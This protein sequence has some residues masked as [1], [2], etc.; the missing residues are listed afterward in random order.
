MAFDDAIYKGKTSKVIEVMIR[1]S[2]TGQGK[3]GIAF[4]SVAA[5]YMREGASASSAITVVTATLGTWTSGGWVEVDA[6]NQPG[7][8]Q[9]GVPNAALATGANSVTLSFKISG[10]ID[11]AVKFILID[12]DLR[13]P[14]RAGLTAL[15]NVA[16]GGA[17]QLPTADSSGR[18]T[19]ITNSD[20][21]GY[22]LA[23]SE[24]LIH[25]QNTAQAGSGTTITLDASASS[26]DNFYVGYEI[27]LYSG[28]GSPQSR[29][30]T[31]YNGTTKVATVD[32]PWLGVNPA[33]GTV[34]VIRHL[35]LSA[36][37]ASAKSAIQSADVQTGLTNQGY[38]TTRAAFLDTLNGLVA[39]I[40]AS[41]GRTLTGFGTLVADIWANASRTLSDKAGFS[42]ATPPP[43]AADIRAEIDANSTKLDV[44]VGSR[45]A[46]FAYA[47]PPTVAA[48]RS[49]MDSNSTKLANLDAPVSGRAAP[50]DAMTLTGPTITSIQS[51]LATSASITTLA[52]AVGVVD[53]FVD[54]E[55]N[56]I[57][58]VTDKL[59][60]LLEAD[61][62]T[63]R[64]TVAGLA[65]APAGGGGGGGTADW[66]APEREQIRYRLGMDGTKVAPQEPDLD[67]GFGVL[68]VH[69]LG[70]D[71]DTIT[72]STL[73][74]DALDAID[75][76]LTETHGSGSWTPNLTGARTVQLT[77]RDG[78][79][80]NLLPNVPVKVRIGG[81]L[82]DRKFTDS[83][84]RTDFSLDDGDYLVS[85][86]PAL[87][88]SSLVDQALTVNSEEA[89]TVLLDPI[90]PDAPD[91]PDTRA[92]SVFVFDGL[93]RPLEGKA[94]T[95]KLAPGLSPLTLDTALVSR[96]VQEATTDSDGYAVLYLL[97]QDVFSGAYL[98]TVE[99]T[100]EATIAV[101]PGEG[102]ISL[103][104]LL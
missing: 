18:V 8:Y 31:A 81:Q 2:T 89:A 16:Q 60:T 54:T 49:E 50:G 48:I 15:P 62:P 3:T 98:V 38:T 23:A 24:S 86:G 55:V 25:R 12:V 37:D 75:A 9:F 59:N 45:M 82:V 76:T 11:K 27:S 80:N 61:G 28:T 36:L 1:D 4:G 88:Y 32:S 96:T 6:T 40:W 103:A 79:T 72:A 99:D 22:G 94:V 33:S 92:V 19:V 51:G 68:P 41:G 63:F 67:P 13:D 56:S 70:I 90:A 101:P 44:P 17:G 73:A 100:L 65:N 83:F 97:T 29:I 93:G 30:I 64:F 39:A 43:T 34:F 35:R 104:H 21:T 20:K 52:A 87:G 46:T 74:D 77:V 95:A 5:R 53:D 91:S 14:V 102:A 10:A 7:L 85:Y 57:K 84:G 78:S 42:L 66:T 71:D 26:T 69:V 47:A 58:G